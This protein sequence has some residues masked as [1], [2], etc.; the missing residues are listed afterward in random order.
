MA[1]A[2]TTPFPL[3]NSFESSA[4]Q[5]ATRF[6][7]I[8]LL[9]YRIRLSKLLRTYP[10]LIT[11]QS[12]SHRY[13]FQN[14][15]QPMTRRRHSSPDFV[16]VENHF[17]TRGAGDLRSGWKVRRTRWRSRDDPSVNKGHHPWCRELLESEIESAGEREKK[18]K[19]KEYW[20][21]L[22]CIKYYGSALDTKGVLS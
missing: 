19:T 3:S 4:C 7:R 9:R 20:S 6:Q 21:D 15:P 10:F 17:Q 2:W 14:N 22:V 1:G 5:M 16:N 12:H 13:E 11:I 8:P 18:K